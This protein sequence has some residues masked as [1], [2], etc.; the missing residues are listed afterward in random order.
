MIGTIY[1]HTSPSGRSYIGQTIKFPVELRWKRK[2]AA[3]KDGSVFAN[4]IRKH[5]IKNFTTTILYQIE[6][7]SRATLIEDLNLLEEIAIAEHNTLFPDGYNL[8]SG[9]NHYIRNE[10]TR[11]RM[12]EIAKEKWKDPQYRANVIAAHDY[13]DPEYRKNLS[14]ASQKI[15]TD[16]ERS[17][18]LR[19][20][21]RG[22]K[23]PETRAKMAEVRRA[24]HQK[25]KEGAIA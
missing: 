25:K 22:P 16:P 17:A 12:S 19:A 13:N 9:G 14:I 5:G 24:W 21:L 10:A 8:N 23:S 2:E 4:A 3:Y 1:M 6:A 7:D 18:K 11:K 15:W 20:K